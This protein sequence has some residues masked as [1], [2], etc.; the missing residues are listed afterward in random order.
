MV[1]LF[2]SVRG[3]LNTLLAN[4]NIENDALIAALINSGKPQQR[5]RAQ[6]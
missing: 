4:R 3:S 1:L 6:A 5:T 2:L